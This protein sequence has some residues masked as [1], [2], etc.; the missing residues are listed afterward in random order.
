M[1]KPNNQQK[2]KKISDSTDSSES[3]D[4]PTT[5]NPDD[6][7]MN[8]KKPDSVSKTVTSS[9]TSEKQ[10]TDQTT[11][12]M[13]TTDP[14]IQALHKKI[15]NLIEMLVT[16]DIFNSE[17]KAL[18]T[19][20]IESVSTK[21]QEI[22][23]RMFELETENK[24]LKQEVNRCKQKQDDIEERLVQTL[25]A[26]TLSNNKVNDLEQWTR[27]S[28]VR[29]FGLKDTNRNE[30]HTESEEKVVNMV[31]NKLGIDIENTVDIAH[32]VGRFSLDS[33]RSVIVK[34]KSRKQKIE[35]MKHRKKL[36]GTGISIA[37]DLTTVNHQLL[38]KTKENPIVETAWSSGGNIF[39]KFRNGTIIKVNYDTKLENVEHQYSM[40][41]TN[42]RQTL[43]MDT[44]AGMV[45]STP[46]V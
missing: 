19:D 15:D 3:F 16:K 4:L 5:Q 2:R 37:E 26:I 36:K 31:R 22:E 29:V 21:I 27:K 12:K 24:Q 7:T 39:A 18:K 9:D 44:N 42:I 8:K 32:R 38:R 6:T 28:S 14:Q 30:T 13:F 33:D 41:K 35:V 40:N 43:P 10:K 34:F 25:Y 45:T 11:M 17:I 20:I 1:G 23:G 46:N